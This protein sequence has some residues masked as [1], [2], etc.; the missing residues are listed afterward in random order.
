ML[1]DCKSLKSEAR[2]EQNKNKMYDNVK[3]KRAEKAGSEEAAR[4]K[5]KKNKT[6]ALRRMSRTV[7]S[8][9][10]ESSIQ[11]RHKALGR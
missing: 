3:K 8:S 7:A 11:F 9:M 6:K 5:S 4:D 10:K 2:I 1:S